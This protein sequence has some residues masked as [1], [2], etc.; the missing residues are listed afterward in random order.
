[1]A[2]NSLM[3]P[4]KKPKD[5]ENSSSSVNVLYSINAK[6]NVSLKP[7]KDLLMESIIGKEILASFE[8]NNFIHDKYRNKM[9]HII[10]T[11]LENRSIR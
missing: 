3:N 2:S 11:D 4:A 9:C 1:M 6:F 10:I 8:Q 5:K 7:L